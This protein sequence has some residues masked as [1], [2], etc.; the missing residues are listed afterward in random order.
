MA[1][2]VLIRAVFFAV[3]M[4]MVM[5]TMIVF[6][7]A[8]VFATVVVVFVMAVIVLI[9]A[10][11]F[12][13]MMVRVMM[14]MI[15]FIRALVFAT[16]VVMVV[17]MVIVLIRAVFFAVMMVM[18]MMT[19]IVFIKALVFAAVMVMVMMMVIVRGIQ[20]LPDSHAELAKS[21]KVVVLLAKTGGCKQSFV[22]IWWT[23]ITGTIHH[24]I[25]VAHVVQRASLRVGN[26]FISAR[27]AEVGEVLNEA[28]GGEH[29]VFG[30]WR[31]GI[32]GTQGNAVFV[33]ALEKISKAKGHN[34]CKQSQ[35]DLH[36]QQLGRRSHKA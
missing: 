33:A 1:M 17:M 25:F 9:R 22:N 27:L 6:I 12:A 20:V 36:F 4:V 26:H 18:V 30:I 23:W 13:V 31:G 28:F 35:V 7:R 29:G 5:M 2:I 15:V 34:K 11:F 24:S 32:I 14:T 8:L 16:V 10:V 19:M 3:M 21:G